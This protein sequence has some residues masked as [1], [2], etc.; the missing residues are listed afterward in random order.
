LSS[1]GSNQGRLLAVT[2][3]V[4]AFLA[5]F[6]LA[7]DRWHIELDLHTRPLTRPLTFLV[8]G[9]LVIAVGGGLLTKSGYSNRYASIVFIP[10]LALVVLGVMTLRD[11]RA[12][13]IVLAVAA[14]TGLA[15]AGEN[16]DTQRTQAIAVQSVLAVHGRPGDV[17]AY[18]PDQLGPA[19]YR[20][21]AS[22]G[23]RQVTYPRSTG[24]AIVDWV[25]YKAA[26]HSA[27]PAA[28]VR[29]VQA[30]AGL[31]SIWLVWA[32]GYQGYGTRCESVAT[33]LLESPG[34][35]GHQWVTQRASKY[36]EPMDLTQF[37]K[38]QSAS[39]GQSAGP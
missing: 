27:K 2:Y 28:F 38:L 39:P 15:V 25:D 16:V 36:Y 24:P 14:V 33:L 3:L 6:G 5:V 32:S 19:V 17:V 8:F 34:Y 11:P 12:R 9:T 1:A 20:L 37:K 10:F 31:H 22:G 18:C 7:R 30:E 4:A 35:G 21:T 26:V 13:A 29:A 23:Y